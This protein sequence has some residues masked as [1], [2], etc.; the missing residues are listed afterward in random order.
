MVRRAC[1]ADR[2]DPSWRDLV[3]Q[4]WGTG[5]R[6]RVGDDLASL[7]GDHNSELCRGV[8]AG[9]ICGREVHGGGANW[10]HAARWRRGG[11]RH[12]AVHVVCRGNC[13]VDHCAV[14]AGGCDRLK[15]WHL[16]NRRGRVHGG[17]DGDLRGRGVRHMM[18]GG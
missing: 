13:E 16:D 6:R 2:V 15:R 4:A 7:A 12:G 14:R 11:D 8:V 1:H 18:S 10:E 5:R 9:R 3:V 17:L